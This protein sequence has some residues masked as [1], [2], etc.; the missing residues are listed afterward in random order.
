M[1]DLLK[2]LTEP[3]V[4]DLQ[5]C[6]FYDFLKVKPLKSKDFFQKKKSRN[7]PSG[8]ILLKCDFEKS[9]FRNLLGCFIYLDHP[10]TK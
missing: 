5:P 1:E 9:D 7:A 3:I 10:C 4:I 6:D 8:T 2:H